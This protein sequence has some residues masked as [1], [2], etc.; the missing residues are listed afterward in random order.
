MM[1]VALLI[2]FGLSI[3]SF[4]S[5]FEMAVNKAKPHM[6]YI[7]TLDDK[8]SPSVVSLNKTSTIGWTEKGGQ[9]VQTE[10]PMVK[11]KFTP[12]RIGSNVKLE[13]YNEFI[14]KVVEGYPTAQT[15]EF[16]QKKS[17]TQY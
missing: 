3:F 15:V 10:Q 17:V 9:D 6:Y 2:W 13:H 12:T 7:Q 5:V 1:F 14:S 11:P 16:P 8:V 4:S